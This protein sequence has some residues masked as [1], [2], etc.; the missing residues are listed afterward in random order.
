MDVLAAGHPEEYLKGLSFEISNGIAA[1]K[2]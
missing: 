2:K 1:V